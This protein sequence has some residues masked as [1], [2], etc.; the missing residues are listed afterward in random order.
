[1]S[2]LKTGTVLFFQSLVT[3]GFLNW[4]CSFS[5]HQKSKKVVG[6]E[7]QQG[8]R[9]AE[10]KQQWGIACSI[11]S[12]DSDCG[13]M[14]R[15]W[16]CL[17]QCGWVGFVE[18]LGDCVGLWTGGGL[19]WFVDRWGIFFW[20]MVLYV[21]SFVTRCIGFRYYVPS[22]CFEWFFL[23]HGAICCGEILISGKGHPLA[24]QLLLEDLARHYFELYL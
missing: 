20:D 17:M 2:V 13:G 15:V 5:L 22:L 21:G 23:G 8:E 14:M 6:E 7:G 16:V 24:R 11:F 19:C 12:S 9:P 1:L 10:C 4:F 18:P 3:I